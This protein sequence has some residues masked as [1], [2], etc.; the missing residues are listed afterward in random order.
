MTNTSEF[1]KLH[2]AE[3]CFIIPN[4][5]DVGTARMLESIGFRALATTSAG[6]AFSLGL[7][8]GQATR[9]QV[10]A[11]CADIVSATALPVSAD[12]ENGFGHS[13]ESAAG[14][15]VTVAAVGLAG[16][17]LEDHTG[18][19][20]NPIYEFEHAVERI[21]AA[22]EARDALPGDF[23]LTA[24]CENFLWGRADLDDTIRR[25][26]AFEAAGADVLY[27]PGLRDLTM[28]AQV[29]A[30]VTKP[31]NVVMGMPGAVFTV[32]ELAQAGV[33]RISV[34]SA[35]A[36]LAYGTFVDAARDMH[37]N[38]RFDLAGK[39]MGFA[40]LEGLLPD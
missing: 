9:D 15:I 35:L 2:Q 40:E 34:G 20:A 29:C 12:L 33:K 11:H 16:G 18:D 39:A 4:P 31:V 25:L 19:P 17:S 7:R 14:T 28:I 3:G 5:W 8:E 32:A 23:V 30:A 27:A 21:A 10:L 38:G 13:P 22:A 1:R 36:R 6:M 24:R 26:Q 37:E